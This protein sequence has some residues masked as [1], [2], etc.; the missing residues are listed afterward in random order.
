MV[1]YRL[2]EQFGVMERFDLPASDTG[3]LV[4][5]VE[6]ALKGKAVGDE[7]AVPLTPAEGF[8]EWNP[9]MTFSDREMLHR[10]DTKAQGKCKPIAV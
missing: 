2:E 6:Q 1:I 9:E 3:S 8:G 7:V 10:K 5:K 4:E